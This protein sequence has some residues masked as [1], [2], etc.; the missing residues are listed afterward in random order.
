MFTVGSAFY[1]LFFIVTYHM[2]P[3]IDTA[4]SFSV[5]C[6]PSLKT[7]RN[8]PHWSLSRTCEHGLAAAMLVFIAMDAWRLVLGPV[9]AKG[10]PPMF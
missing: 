7:S 4:A 5:P 1:A 10:P 9:A 8:T 2:F 6:T 3:A